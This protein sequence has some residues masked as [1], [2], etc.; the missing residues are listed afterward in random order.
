LTLADPDPRV[1]QH[2]FYLVTLRYR[3][4]GFAGLD[5]DTVI[6]AFGAEGIPF[7]PTYPH[8]LYKNAVFTDRDPRYRE[9][10]LPEAE[11]LC[12]DGI[13]LNHTVFLGDHGDVDD[14]IRAI[15]KVQSEA[16]ALRTSLAREETV[17]KA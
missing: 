7:K 10:Y 5:R 13:W 15:E 11:R 1:E 12:R 3:P 9:L 6:R 16:A 14:M 8:P 2:P 17:A 4:E